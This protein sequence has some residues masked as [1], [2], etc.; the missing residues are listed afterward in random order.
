LSRA[1]KITTLEL[2]SLKN[3]TSL[4][5]GSNH[6]LQTL[7]AEG[8]TGITNELDLTGASNIKD[9]SLR[10]STFNNLNLTTEHTGTTVKTVNIANTAI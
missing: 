4:V 9:V 8:L 10:G 6:Y 3:L 7:I 2:I 1:E 5:L